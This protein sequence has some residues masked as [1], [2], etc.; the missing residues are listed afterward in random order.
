MFLLSGC[1][2]DPLTQTLKKYNYAPIIP[3]R[4]TANVG[5]IYNTKGLLDPYIFMS[6][7]LSDYIT[8]LMEQ[9]KDDASI[10]DVE[11]EKQFNIGAETDIIGIAEFELSAYGITKFKVRFSGVVQYIISQ[12]M[13]EDK[14]YP[15]IKETYPDRNL[16]KKFVIT[17]LLK[18]SKLEYEFY[19]KDGIKVSVKPESQI[20][21]VLKAKFGAGWNAS[22]NNNLT[23]T[24][25]RFIGYRMA[26]LNEHS[27]SYITKGT[28]RLQKFE[29]IEIPAE[30]LRKI[31]KLEK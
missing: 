4:A 8:Q 29:L 18:V 17:A 27:Y 25:P 13:F 28:E 19:N 22:E 26:Q 2:S 31:M 16:D 1:A 7:H 3:L 20:E 14:L 24:E 15:K 11:G 5:D 23:T 6:D 12:T 9:I 30:E 21:K 10:P